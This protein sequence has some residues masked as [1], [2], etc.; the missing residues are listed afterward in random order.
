M[1]ILLIEP[2]VVLAKIYKEAFARLG[3]SVQHVGDA[4]AGILAADEQCPDVVV[5]ELLLANHSG[6]AF[7]YEFRT[8]G[9][10]LTVPVVVHTLIP[11]TRL[12]PFGK[13][14]RE[15]GVAA[16]LYKPETS[17]QTL[18]RTIQNCK[19]VSI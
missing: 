3:H 2:D 18:L 1:H 10:W 19:P 14:F 17:L 6:A 13:S 5:L 16:S 8:Y 15:L 4:Q 7:L 12:R 11:P 9:D